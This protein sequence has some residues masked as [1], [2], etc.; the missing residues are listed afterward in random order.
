[1]LRGCRPKPT[2]LVQPAKPAP[3]VPAKP[4]EMPKPTLSVQPSKPVEPTK[5]VSTVTVPPAVIM[6]P[7]PAAGAG[8]AVK[9]QSASAV[10][11]SSKQG[12]FNVKSLEKAKGSV[13]DRLKELSGRSYDV[14]EDRFLAKARVAVRK[15]L[16]TGR[17]LFFSLPEEAE[18]LVYNYL[19]DHYSD[20]Y[21]DWENSQEKRTLMG[22]GFDLPSVN[23]IIDECYRIL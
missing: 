18:D 1:M 2:K 11:E 16:G 7:K 8:P 10:S 20:P 5:L 3:P 21:M 19:R 9:T 23:P 6:P 13:S 22:M 17:G 12:V 15:V 14:Y 4:A